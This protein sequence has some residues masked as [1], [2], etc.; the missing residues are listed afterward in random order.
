VTGGGRFD[1]CVV[2]AGMV[3]LAT[4]RALTELRP[5]ISVLVLDK[6]DGV[7]RHQS[8]H[9]SGVVHSG[10]YYKPGSLK[11]ELCVEGREAMY[12]LCDE[13]GIAAQR[14]GK[15]VIATVPSEFDALDEL[16]RRGRANGLAGLQRLASDEIADFEPHA[17]GLAA[18]LVPEAGVADFPG[19]AAHVAAQLTRAG[20]QIRT[21]HPVE[22]IEHRADGVEVI[23]GG[24][25]HVAR[26]L[27]NCAGLHSDRVAALAGVTPRV[28]IVPFR[29]EY[30][31]LAEPVTDL[32]R[33]L[34]YPVPDPR[35]PF[36]G[37][38]FTRRIDG[39]VEVGPNAVLALGREHYRGSRPNWSDVGETLGHRGFRRL[40]ARHWQSGARE[41]LNSRSRRLY[42]GLAA[43]LVPGIKA[44]D[45]LEGG[46]GVRAQAVAPDGA[47]VDDFVF[48]EAGSTVHVLNAP[49]PGATA[50]L[51]IGRHIATRT[52]PVLGR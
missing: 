20:A 29:G 45:L 3:G 19:V 40:A 13:A 50:S 5:G 15:L 35:F 36:L 17:V 49:S 42:A 25:R 32:V 28:R 44:A 4:A 41:L 23:A 8:S 38:H 46:S 30:Y 9:N 1:V 7:A 27:I 12:A 48:E 37:V 6:E 33:A 24:E 47:L 26:A 21:A 34:I 16:E 22:G 14:S 31:K 51:A 11:A 2:G 52:L 18:L 43:R 10:L 39:S